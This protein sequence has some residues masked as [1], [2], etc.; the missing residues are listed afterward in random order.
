MLTH[1]K[2]KIGAMGS[3]GGALMEERDALTAF[4]AALRTL[5][6]YDP[7]VLPAVAPNAVAGSLSAATT[8][9]S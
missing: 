9:N 7:G 2:L 5:R 4:G 1:M 6:R 8:Y 3:A